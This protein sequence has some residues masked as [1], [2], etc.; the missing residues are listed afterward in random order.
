MPFEFADNTPTAVTGRKHRRGRGSSGSQQKTSSSCSF[1]SSAKGGKYSS[2]ASTSLNIAS[3]AGSKGIEQDQNSCAGSLTYSAS[4]SVFSA[5]D[6]ADSSFAEIIKILDTEG[7]DGDSKFKS[8]MSERPDRLQN[9]C[10]MDA[11]AVAGWMQRAE[12]RSKEQQ[13][14]RQLEQKKSNSKAFT[15][16][17]YSPDEDDSSDD[18]IQMLGT[19]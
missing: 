14:I 16:M 13:K 7:G 6:S 19:M 9:A 10:G 12:E 15:G 1:G 17:R 11:P 8:F 5:E 2:A 18:E 4:S 3:A